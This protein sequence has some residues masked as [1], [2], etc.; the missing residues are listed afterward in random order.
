M[1]LVRLSSSQR[2]LLAPQ[3]TRPGGPLSD[4]QNAL[5]G[6]YIAQGT[7]NQKYLSKSD[8]QWQSW[9]AF[10]VLGRLD[11]QRRRRVRFVR[12]WGLELQLSHHYTLT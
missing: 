7:P 10:C 6:P 1:R 3:K 8:R 5:C 9:V 4:G 11:R 12:K 2:A